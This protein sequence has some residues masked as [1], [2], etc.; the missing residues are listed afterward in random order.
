MSSKN[1]KE[2]D[3]L[4]KDVQNALNRTLTK[5][6]KEQSNFI[7]NH[8]AL[9]KKKIN[10]FTTPK[11]ARPDDM[12]ISLFTVRKYITPA[13]L[14][15]KVSRSGVAVTISKQKSIFLSGFAQQTPRRGAG[16][17]L[18]SSKNSSAGIFG[19]S[20]HSLRSSYTASGERRLSRP[21]DA[22]I[23]KRLNDD[24]SEFALKDVDALLEKAQE[25][26]N[27]ELEK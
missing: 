7:T 18:I 24:L 27:Q 25:I 8:I 14:P 13:M 20:R 15:R 12:S 3:R 17:F 10:F 5:V 6:K 4:R 22:F 21:R 2:L 19:V 23:V 11:R 1:D 26:F 9:A 16:K